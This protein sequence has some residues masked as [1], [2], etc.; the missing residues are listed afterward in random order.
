MPHILVIAEHLNGQLNPA[1]AR[2]V[3]AATALAAFDP[4]T[5]IDIAVLAADPANIASEAARINDVSRVLAV[6]HPANAHPIAQV[7]AAQIIALASD[8]S[9]IFLKRPGSRHRRAA[10]GQSNL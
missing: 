1:T 8:Y 9:H 5:R 3:S 7:L 10:W 2:T 6:A 4:A